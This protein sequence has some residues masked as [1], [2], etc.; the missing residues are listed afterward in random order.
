[1]STDRPGRRWRRVHTGDGFVI[2]ATRGWIQ[3]R[4][5]V[6]ETDPRYDPN[7]NAAYA[8]RVYR[9]DGAEPGW[10]VLFHPNLV[11]VPN[12][13]AAISSLISEAEDRAA[14]FRRACEQRARCER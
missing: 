4:L 10:T 6:A 2:D 9:A 13:D 14:Q 1:M 12:R 3:V 11:H 7:F 8:W 5:T